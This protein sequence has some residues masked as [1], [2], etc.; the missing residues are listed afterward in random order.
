VLLKKDIQV[1]TQANVSTYE[2]T[3]RQYFHM[4]QYWLS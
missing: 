3:K 2:D 4:L 1:S